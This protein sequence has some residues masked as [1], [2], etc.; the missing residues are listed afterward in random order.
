VQPGD[1]G[2]SSW[3]RLMGC[4]LAEGCV[5]RRE[6]RRVEMVVATDAVA[7]AGPSARGEGR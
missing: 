1:G 5:G 7:V 4:G 6:G 2:V 3:R